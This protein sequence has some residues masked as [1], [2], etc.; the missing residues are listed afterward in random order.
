MPSEEVRSSFNELL[1]LLSKTTLALYE[2]YEEQTNIQALPKRL[3]DSNPLKLAEAENVNSMQGFRE[4][5]LTLLESLYLDLRKEFL[6]IS[7]GRKSR[8]GKSFEE[9][10]ALLL[11]LADFPFQ[12]QQAHLRTDFVLPS[13]SAFERNRTSCVVASLKRTLRERWQEVAGELKQLQAPNVF[14][15]TGDPKVSAGQVHGICDVHRIH[16]VVRDS[17]KDKHPGNPLVLGF[18]EFA[19]VR[20][21][22]LQQQWATAGLGERLL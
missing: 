11:K 5:A 1:T 2:K 16:L 9:Q 18:T 4:A 19:N 8:G 21:P 6:S 3:L 14:L 15:V 17:V 22:M 20:L 12:Q 10:F 7:Q 13:S